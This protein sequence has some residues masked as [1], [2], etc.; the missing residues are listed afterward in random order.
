MFINHQ[1]HMTYSYMKDTCDNEKEKTVNI[2]YIIF[3]LNCILYAFYVF[4][5]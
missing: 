5:R 4:I 2:K 1:M 3:F